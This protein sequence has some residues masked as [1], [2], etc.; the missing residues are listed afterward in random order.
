[1]V[2]YSLTQSYRIQIQPL[3]YTKIQ[4]PAGPGDRKWPSQAGN[5]SPRVQS[6]QG[7]L[8][9]LKLLRVLEGHHLA[10]LLHIVHADP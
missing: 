10:I 2:S 8:G 7:V 3:P 1:M 9:D 4:P 5:L 6:S